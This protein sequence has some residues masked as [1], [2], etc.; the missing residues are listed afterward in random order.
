MIRAVH[1]IYRC[2]NYLPQRVGINPTPTIYRRFFCAEGRGLS[3]PVSG[4]PETTEWKYREPPPGKKIRRS[5]QRY[6]TR[7]DKAPRTRH[8]NQ[9]TQPR[10]EGAENPAS[11][12]KTPPR[13]E[14]AENPASQS[15]T[16]P[17]REGAENPASQSKTQPRREGRREPGIAIKNT[18][19]PRRRREPGIMAGIFVG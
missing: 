10:R 19:E 5:T 2:F 18:T 13:R 11:Q 7:G 12:S 1:P 16:P 15:K 8:H 14:G 9:K 17:R 4:R 3:P 6:Q